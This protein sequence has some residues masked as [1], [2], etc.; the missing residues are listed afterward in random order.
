MIHQRLS[1][2]FVLVCLLMT[3]LVP[4]Y[5]KAPALLLPAA[6]S[7]NLIVNG[8]AETGAGSSDGYSVVL[9]P[10]WTTQG[11][12]TVVQYAA[13]GGFPDVNTPGPAERGANFFAGGPV[14]VASSATQT[15]DLSSYAAAIDTGRQ[16]YTLSGYFGGWSSQGDNAT[17][18][19]NFK[20]TANQP[21]GT[22]T[23]GPVTNVERGNQTAFF[24]RTINGLVPA[25]SRN[26][27]VSLQMTRYLGLYNDG[28]A[29]NLFLGLGSASGG[30]ISGK[31]YN[32][33]A[34]AG[35]EVTGAFIQACLTGGGCQMTTS[36]S[37]G[38]YWFINLAAGQYL[39]RAF[40]PGGNNRL[41]GLLGPLTLPENSTLLDQNII[42]L[43]PTGLPAGTAIT[44][45]T[46]SN[47]VPSVYWQNALTLT[48]TG[49]S[50]GAASYQ[51]L[52]NGAVIRSGSMVESPAGTY[53]ATIAPLYPLHGDARVVIT[54]QCPG[55][56]PTQI[57][58][59]IWIDPSGVVV[60]TNGEP[61]PAA[62]V[63]LYRADVASG[64]FEIVISGS[65]VMSPGN[66]DNSMQTDTA[67]LFGWDVIAGYYTVR[68]AKSGCV[69]AD[70][71]SQ[72]YAQS[73]VLTIPPPVTDLRLVLYC[74]EQPLFRIYL[75]LVIR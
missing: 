53:T 28:Y 75:P 19:I 21:L 12:F 4:V 47:G 11:N 45:G 13:G 30:V 14:N 54:L 55:C 42:L 31:V 15:I 59:N 48:T 39:L 7:D 74:G 51:V 66:R 44:P 52:Q 3:G 23:I 38:S 57:P 5:A 26:V 9:V 40:P 63:T 24:N 27:E 50:A 58:F 33:S 25:Q 71:H 22:A 6:T 37:D 64:P 10:G 72:P 2:L 61:V 73:D 8:D 70:N 41:S 34:T 65:A 69:A 49:C 16:T 56:E 20:D 35:N 43:Q 1:I 18:T 36:N 68:A 46:T 32:E 29:D 62:T 67:G 60:N 17:L